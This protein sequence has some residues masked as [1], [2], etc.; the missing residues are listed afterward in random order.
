MTSPALCLPLVSVPP[1]RGIEGVHD[2]FVTPVI[3]GSGD[4][5]GLKGSL[6]SPKVWTSTSYAMTRLRLLG[7]T[8]RLHAVNDAEGERFLSELLSFDYEL[9]PTRRLRFG[10][11]SGKHDDR[12]FAAALAVLFEDQ[13]ARE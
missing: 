7:E 13:D 1:D 9:T 8:D 10:A 12:V 5:D 6:Y 2:I 11:R 3:F 4:V